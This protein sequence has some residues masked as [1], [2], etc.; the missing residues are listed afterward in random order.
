[1]KSVSDEGF[2]HTAK[3]LDT[4]LRAAGE[5]RDCDKRFF[6]HS[7]ARKHQRQQVAAAGWPQGGRRPPPQAVRGRRE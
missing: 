7:L 1:M 2:C 4:A 5:E 6:K 3:L